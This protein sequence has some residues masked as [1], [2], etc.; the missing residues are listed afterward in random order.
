MTQGCFIPECYFDTVLLKTILQTNEPVNHKK[1]CNNVMKAMKD[2]RLKDSFAVGIVDKDK[3]DLD[4]LMEFD[5]H[6]FGKLVLHKHKQKLQYVIQ[7]NPPL[8]RWLIEVVNEAGVNI[9]EYGLPNDVGRLQKITKF[10]FAEETLELRDL[11][12]AL[13]QSESETIKRLSAW[14]LYLKEHTY[15]ADTNKLING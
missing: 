1:G 3:R 15:H 9:E 6:E 7:L 10:E 5:K 11:C 14:L 12:K 2:G 4:Y 13:L 8:E